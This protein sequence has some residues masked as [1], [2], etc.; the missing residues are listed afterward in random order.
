MKLIIAV[1][2][3]LSLTATAQAQC[4]PTV[5]SEQMFREK[6]NETLVEYGH[7]ANGEIIKLYRNIEKDTWSI[8]VTFPN[9]MECPMTAGVGWKSLRQVAGQPA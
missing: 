4:W 5:S 3:L 8:T 9:G 7:S 2:V 6:W 1:F